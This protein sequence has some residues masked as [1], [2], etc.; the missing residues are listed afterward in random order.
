MIVTATQ[1]FT[2]GNIRVRRGHQL[3]IVSTVAAKLRDAGLV[4]FNGLPGDPP[5]ESAGEPQSASPAGQAA[6]QTTS[7]E[8]ADGDSET[9]PKRKR[10]AKVEPEATEPTTDGE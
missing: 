7:N 5:P 3:N 10:K 6:P 4:S 9:K 8:S 1:S 2:H